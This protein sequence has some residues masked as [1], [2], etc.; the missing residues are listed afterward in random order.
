MQGVTGLCP[1]WLKYLK[2]SDEKRLFQ[3]W[4]PPA[5]ASSLPESGQNIES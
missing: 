1:L 3:S 5:E 4:R 2:L